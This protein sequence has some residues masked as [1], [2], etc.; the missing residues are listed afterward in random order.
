MGVCWPGFKSGT[1]FYLLFSEKITHSLQENNTRKK[2]L[3]FFFFF[4][5]CFHRILSFQRVFLPRFSIFNYALLS[6]WI[7]FLFHFI[8]FFYFFREDVLFNFCTGKK[9]KKK[10]GSLSVRLCVCSA[11]ALLNWGNSKNWLWIALLWKNKTKRLPLCCRSMR[12]EIIV[13]YR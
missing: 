11:E 9:K 4:C 5:R 3:L 12:G 13:Q 7:S 10:P 6:V 2:N 8:I 1:I